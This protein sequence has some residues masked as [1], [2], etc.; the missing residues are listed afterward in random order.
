MGEDDVELTLSGVVLCSADI[1]ASDGDPS[2]VID[3]LGGSGGEVM[4]AVAT[5]GPAI[6]TDVPKESNKPGPAAIGFAVAALG[7]AL[8]ISRRSGFTKN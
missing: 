6:E 5:P 2:A 7:A 4:P 8:Y 1:E 3:D